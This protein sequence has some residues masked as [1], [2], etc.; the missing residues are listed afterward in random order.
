MKV[1]GKMGEEGEEDTGAGSPFE[2]EEK[3]VIGMRRRGRASTRPSGFVPAG[4]R[5]WARLLPPHL[6]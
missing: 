3:K 2:D 4:G 1:D 5:K 6:D